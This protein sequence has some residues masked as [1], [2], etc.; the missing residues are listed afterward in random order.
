[1]ASG[2]DPQQVFTGLVSPEYFEILGARF[3]AGRGFTRDEARPG[4]DNVIVL[5]EGYC[6]SAS[7]DAGLL[8]RD[9]AVDGVLCRVIGIVPDTFAST[10]IGT[11]SQTGVY[12]PISRARIGGMRVPLLT[13]FAISRLRDG[14][15]RGINCGQRSWR[16]WRLPGVCF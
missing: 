14:A 7:R 8:G 16:C 9:L 2:G 11:K 5:R 1:V 4:T 3:L 6:G 12:L 15:D 13:M 10:V